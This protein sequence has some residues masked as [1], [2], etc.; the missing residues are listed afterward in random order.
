M[1]GMIPSATPIS[2]TISAASSTCCSKENTPIVTAS[3]SR[4]AHSSTAG[5][6]FPP[7]F[8]QI[9]VP[10]YA[11]AMPKSSITTPII[12]RLTFLSTANTGKK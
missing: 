5:R 6:T 3:T 1:L 9:H 4:H 7:C 11:V 2:S 8:L 12:S 10:I